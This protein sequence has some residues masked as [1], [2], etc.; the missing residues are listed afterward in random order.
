MKGTGPFWPF[1]LKLFKNMQ[2]A[3][4]EIKVQFNEMSTKGRHV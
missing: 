3:G 2:V 4:V 1:I